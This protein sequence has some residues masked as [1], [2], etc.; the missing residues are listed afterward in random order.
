M[1]PQ[2]QQ[3]QLNTD[4][5]RVMFLYWG[6]RGAMPQFTLELGRA[7]M[8]S[9]NISPS[10]CISR[11]NELYPSFEASG[12]ALYPVE[13]FATHLGALTQSWRLALIKRNLAAYLIEQRIEAVIDLMPHVWSPA[14][15]PTIQLAGGRYIPVLHDAAPHPGDPMTAWAQRR[16]DQSLSKADLII[17]L[18]G[19]VAS[20]FRSRPRASKAE[21]AVLFHP[22][23]T[24]GMPSIPRSI[25]PGEPIRLLFLGRILP[26]KGLPLF[27]DAVD[28]LRRDGIA[29]DIGVFGEGHLGDAACRLA[30]NAEVVNRWLTAAE[31]A[32]VL[33]RYHAVVLSHTEASQSGVAAAAFGAGVPVIAT[34]IGGLVEQ[35]GDGVTGV[36]A[37]RVDAPA[38]AQAVRHLFGTPG[39]YATC[40]NN[41]AARRADRSMSRFVERCAVLAAAHRPGNSA[42]M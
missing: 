14:I 2:R 41:I 16:I 1:G 38:L 4:P 34:P 12:T 35:V 42:G 20:E 27:L 5:A 30:G 24:Y 19:S 39:L 29:V 3:P 37:R 26:Y 9:P 31:I 17:A 13:T 18:S 32:S 6:R 15:A 25:R 21:I 28:L 10:V 22:D 8:A 40:C 33:S 23:L 11:Q 36:L 7:A